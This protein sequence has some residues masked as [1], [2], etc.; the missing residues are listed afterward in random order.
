MKIGEIW[1]PK[2]KCKK[3]RLWNPIK[4]IKIENKEVQSGISLDIITYKDINSDNC[5]A[6]S[7]ESFIEV[8]EKD[9]NEDR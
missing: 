1:R 2:D 9:Y 7:R 6:Q 8:Y 4:I 5:I 3:L